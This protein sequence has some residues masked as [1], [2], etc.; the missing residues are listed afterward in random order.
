MNSFVHITTLDQL[1]NHSL[2]QLK[3]QVILFTTRF[4]CCNALGEME[5][6]AGNCLGLVGVVE[7][8]NDAIDIGGVGIG[9]L[10]G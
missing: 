4:P 8:G 6:S 3:I 1:M 10:V 7:A 5:E 2:E 9:L